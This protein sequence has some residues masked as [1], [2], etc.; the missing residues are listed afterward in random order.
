MQKI[1]ISS[2]IPSRNYSGNPPWVTSGMLTE[3][4]S[5]IRLRISFGISPSYP[6]EVLEG[7]SLETPK[8]TPSWMS[9]ICFVNVY[10]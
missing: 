3:I 8:V 9:P 2:E 1:G 7:S 10:K 4:S 6:K 5:S